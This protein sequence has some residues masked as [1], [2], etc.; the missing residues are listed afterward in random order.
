MKPTMDTYNEM[1][2]EELSFRNS[3]IFYE[4]KLRLLLRGVN[5]L[6]IWERRRFTKHGL[7]RIYRDYGK[8]YAVTEEAKKILE[9]MDE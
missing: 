3:V 2:L 1:S 6:T 8:R 9:M 7:I 4:D 5:E